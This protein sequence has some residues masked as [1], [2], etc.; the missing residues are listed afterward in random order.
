MCE[1]YLLEN[2]CSCK[3]QAVVTFITVLL[4]LSPHK[5]RLPYV[6]LS[7]PASWNSSH[8]L[9][10]RQLQQPET[11]TKCQ[12]HTLNNKINVS[13]GCC[14]SWKYSVCAV[15]CY[16][17]SLTLARGHSDLWLC[18]NV[19]QR[20]RPIITSIYVCVFCD[21]LLPSPRPAPFSRLRCRIHPHYV[22][23]PCPPQHTHILTH[24]YSQNG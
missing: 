12:K 11:T 1:Q 8:F 14:F 20:R 17:F 10:I 15:C 7:P 21:T 9:A 22:I 3:Q 19:L 16:Q 23:P 24:A 6:L 4:P 18:K 2:I 13:P 5:H